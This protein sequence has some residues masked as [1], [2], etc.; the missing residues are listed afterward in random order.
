MT[1]SP[2]P[3]PAGGPL[4]GFSLQ[5]DGEGNPDRFIGV[6]VDAQFVSVIFGIPVMA[7]EVFAAD[8]SKNV[9]DLAAKAKQRQSALIVANADTLNTLKGK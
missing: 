9:I 3:H 1:D 6:H 5:P 7:A 4:F 2:T 8:F